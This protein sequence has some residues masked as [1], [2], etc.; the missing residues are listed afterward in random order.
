MSFCQKCKICEVQ[1]NSPE[2]YEKLLLDVIA[3]DSTLFTRWDEVEESWKLVE[4]ITVGKRKTTPIFPNYAPGSWGPEE[5]D[6]LLARDHRHWWNIEE[7]D[8]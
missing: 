6:T 8:L 4:N 7:E 2:A 5:A 3:G 1:N